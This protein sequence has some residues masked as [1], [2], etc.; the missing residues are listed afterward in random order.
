MKPAG[1]T[2]V[3][4]DRARGEVEGDDAR[5]ALCRRQEYFATPPWAGRALGEW[6]GRLDP[7]GA[8]A[9]LAGG[10]WCWE[11]ACGEGH[12][13]HGL[14]TCGVFSRVYAT[15]I[16][17]WAAEAEAGRGSCIAAGTLQ[18]GP[19]LDFLSPESD[20]IDQADWIVFNPPFTLAA[21]FVATA[22]RRAR[23]GVLCLCR[24][25]WLDTAGRHDLFFGVDRPC[26]LELVFF[27]RVNMCLGR[28]EPRSTEKGGSTAT[29][30]S[31]FIW[32]QPGA[33]P[34]W[35]D[36]V[37]AAVRATTGAHGIV[38]LSIAPGAKQRLTHPAD[39][40]AWGARKAAPLFKGELG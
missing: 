29:A 18:A 38:A 9:E 26:D 40:R 35:L 20:R 36:D 19:P 31:G 37:Q 4:A 21:D 33:R 17:D 13:A 32:F 39:A 11:P 34:A 5:A 27:D 25:G 1:H 6:I 23:R 8:A 16:V 28:W 15:D 3:M 30:Y 14:G 10:L 12:L 24:S 2:A 22:L 7:G